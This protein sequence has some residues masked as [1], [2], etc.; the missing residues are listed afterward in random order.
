MDLLDDQGR[1]VLM[2][3]RELRV[4][5]VLLVTSVLKVTKEPWDGMDQRE[6]E[7]YQGRLALLDPMVLEVSLG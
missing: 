1:L 5:Q 2:V 6:K 3:H 7:A 4:Q